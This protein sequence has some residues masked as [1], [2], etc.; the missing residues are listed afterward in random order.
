MAP[1]SQKKPWTTVSL[2]YREH[3]H[4][5]RPSDPRVSDDVGIGDPVVVHILTVVNVNSDVSPHFDQDSGRG[6]WF[7]DSTTS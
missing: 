4:H 1:P 2:P 6:R 5:R 3:P 7:S